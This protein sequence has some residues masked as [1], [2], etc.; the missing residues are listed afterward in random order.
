MFRLRRK[1]E[2]EIIKISV[3][4]KS[5]EERK[6]IVSDGL[7]YIY[8]LFKEMEEKDN[9]IKLSGGQGGILLLENLPEAES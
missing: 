1:K 6:K 8:Y 3:S 9:D 4:D 7:K 5:E 2:I